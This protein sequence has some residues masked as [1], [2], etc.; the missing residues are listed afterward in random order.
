M[1]YDHDEDDEREW[2]PGPLQPLPESRSV[3]HQQRVEFLRLLQDG[4]GR[5]MAASQLGISRATLKRTMAQSPSFR[6]AVVHVEQLR[7]DNLYTGLYVA[8]L[9]GDTRAAMFL[10][11]RAKR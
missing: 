1:L 5:T 2:R 7:L 10:L 9:E 4:L 6:E 8:A 11:S 3:D